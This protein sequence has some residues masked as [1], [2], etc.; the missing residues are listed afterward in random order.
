MFEDAK[1]VMKGRMSK[2]DWQYN[3]QTM[4]HNKGPQNTTQKTNYWETRTPLKTGSARSMLKKA[5]SART[6][7]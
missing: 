4:A 7:I 6:M 1:G 3:G 5:G 2:T